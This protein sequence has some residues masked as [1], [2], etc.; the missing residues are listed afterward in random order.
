MAK[1]STEKIDWH[2]LQQYKKELTAIQER[3]KTY[4][5]QLNPDKWLMPLSEFSEKLE[6][7][8]PGTPLVTH[9][10]PRQPT[11]TSNDL[12]LR[13]DLYAL[14]RIL[15]Y[16]DLAVYLDLDKEPLG[17]T[18]I[19]RRLQIAGE[20]FKS[21]AESP[22]LSVAMEQKLQHLNVPIDRI[23]ALRNSLSHSGSFIFSVREKI[24]KES[25]K[26]DFFRSI[27]SDLTKIKSIVEKIIYRIRLK[28]I[29]SQIAAISNTNFT[30]EMQ[31]L[32][33]EISVSEDLNE[34]T[35]KLN[36]ILE[37]TETLNVGNT[38]KQAIKLQIE[39]ILINLNLKK[40]GKYIQQL[41]ALILDQPNLEDTLANLDKQFESEHYAELTLFK[42]NCVTPSKS[43]IT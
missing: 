23:A 38:E 10:Q 14:E 25:S 34:I 5:T 24:K 4:K 27:Q 42:R 18:I 2:G 19:E 8:T 15:N 28:E 21:S 35:T 6:L 13:K 22:H 1:K 43:A 11:I 7:I 33:T 39:S 37:K 40:L 12:E 36:K 30:L 32:L 29:K 16:F 41:N 9:P 3:F 17:P 26:F 20:Y 31:K